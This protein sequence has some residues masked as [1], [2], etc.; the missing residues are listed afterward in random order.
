MNFPP[1]TVL[2]INMAWIDDLN[3]LTKL[4]E[5]F[6]NDVFLDLPTGRQKP[7]N[8]RYSFTDLS[9]VINKFKIIKYFA[10]SNVETTK[11]INDAY[12]FL[13]ENINLVP[14]IETIKGILSMNKITSSLRD[15]N[16]FVMLDHDDLFSNI[17]ANNKSVDFYL[18]IINDLVNFCNKAGITLLRTR[19]V[20]FS[21]D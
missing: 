11:Q 6:K 2:R 15:S 10:I 3:D 17:V 1:D 13:P 16:R 7:P 12:D 5:G 20:I 4:L 18:E 8:N 9:E 19:G 14:K 21:G